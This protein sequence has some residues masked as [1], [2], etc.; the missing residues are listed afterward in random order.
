MTIDDPLTPAQLVAVAEGAPVA[1]SAAAAARI[2]HAR[3]LVEAI[4]ASGIPAYGVNTGVGALV[5][6]AVDGPAQRRLSR[7]LVM[8]H[9]CGIGA[10]LPDTAVRAIIAAQVN[11][12]AHGRSGVRLAVVEALVALLNHAVIP[13]VPTGGSVGYLTHM[14]HIALVLIGEGQAWVGGRVLPGAA[15]LASAGLVPLVLEAKEGLSLLNGTPC[16][17]GLGCLGWDR[18]RRMVECA[19]GVAAL[20]L[21]ALGAQMAAFDGD[22]L[23]LRVSAGIAQSGASVRQ[24]LAGSTHPGAGRLQDALSLRAVPHVHGAVRDAVAHGEAVL[25]DELRS[26]TDNPVVGGTFAAPCVQS[27]AHA[28]AT[29]LALAMDSLAIA[30]AHLG[31]I[32]E[33]RLDRLVNPLVSGLPPF[34]ASDP[35]VASGFMIAQYSAAALV[36]ENRRLA[37]PAS[38]DGGITSAL[39]E[40]YLAHP[41]A[42]AIKALALLDNVAVILGIE[43]AAA[44][45]AHDLAVPPAARAPGT[46][47]LHRHVRD[48]IAPYADDVPM[49]DV[50]AAAAALIRAGLPP[51]G[52]NRA[53]SS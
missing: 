27:Q 50:I 15:A 10:P 18:A 44:A 22:V 13:V 16:A 29:G 21:E 11:L 12:F 7:Q 30:A 52:P 8:S 51:A 2:G 1:I 49:A 40:D 39:Q 6:T 25:A 38:L 24:W 47:A 33:R 41:T 17:T 32:A 53:T 23:Q 5:N 4:L 42:A 48:H 14:A 43:L 28:V 45:Q 20:T 46:A 3:L 35:G 34:L 26:V 37:A 31:M 36:G 19:D 9:A